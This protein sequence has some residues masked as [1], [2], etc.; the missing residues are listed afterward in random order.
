[1]RAIPGF[2]CGTHILTRDGYV[3]QEESSPALPL[4]LQGGLWRAA[5]QLPLDWYWGDDL[6]WLVLTNGQSVKLGRAQLLLT[7]AGQLVQAQKLSLRDEL[8]NS[9][10]TEPFPCI[11]LRESMPVT[12]RL[13][14]YR[15]LPDTLVCCAGV[16]APCYSSAPGR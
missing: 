7:R 8:M 3:T 13:F 1:M 16:M 10:N 2:L 15:N 6:L 12:G 11:H 9:T 4:V 14:A 5:Q